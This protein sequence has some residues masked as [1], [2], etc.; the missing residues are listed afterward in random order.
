MALTAKTNKEYIVPQQSEVRSSSLY[1]IHISQH[2]N[3][4]LDNNPCSD[5]RRS[6]ENFLPYDIYYNGS[7]SFTFTPGAGNASAGCVPSNNSASSAW[8]S[9]GSMLTPD[10][11]TNR[12]NWDS[13]PYYFHLVGCSDMLWRSWFN[14]NASDYKCYPSSGGAGFQS[15]TS[16]LYW[17]QAWTI[18][19]TKSSTSD[20]Y[21]LSGNLTTKKTNT[22]DNV[23]F[24]LDQCTALQGRHA[25]YS[26]DA[27]LAEDAAS[28]TGHITPTTAEMTV[29]LK[30]LTIRSANFGRGGND[31]LEF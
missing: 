24:A 17:G 7:I 2:T 4:H 9:I 16:S 28:M 20:G 13:N 6:D 30:N 14:P 19:A 11:K 8:L 26:T 10:K 18:S 29:T 5:Y 23:A 15:S 27:V 31:F 22:N 3:H 21:D 12:S 25:S 1:L